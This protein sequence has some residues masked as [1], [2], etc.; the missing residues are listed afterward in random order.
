LIAKIRHDTDNKVSLA[1]MT[2]GNRWRRVS[3][4]LLVGF[5]FD[6]LPPGEMITTRRGVKEPGTGKLVQETFS[7]W[8][9]GQQAND[10][11]RFMLGGAFC[12]FSG[13]VTASN[14]PIGL[15]SLSPDGTRVEE[16]RTLPPVDWSRLDKDELEMMKSGVVYVS[17]ERAVLAGFGERHVCALWYGP[18]S[19]EMFKK[20]WQLEGVYDSAPRITA[21]LVGANLVAM[22]MNRGTTWILPLQTGADPAAGAVN[23]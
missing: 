22:N 8:R 11:R 10:A 13:M 20:T 3:T 21:S 17:R 18:D 9:R 5:V 1:V 19:G 6:E 4:P 2:A 12:G 15:Y 14:N 7:V 23:P 16:S